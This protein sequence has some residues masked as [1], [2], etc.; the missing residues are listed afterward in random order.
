M[1]GILRNRLERLFHLGHKTLAKAGFFSFIPGRCFEQ[2][3]LSH[4]PKF[5]RLSPN[6]QM[7]FVSILPR[8]RALASSQRVNR[9][10]WAS[11]SAI[12]RS[13]ISSCQPGT[14]IAA[15]SRL[16]QICS[17]RSSR[18]AVDNWRALC[19]ISALFIRCLGLCKNDDPNDLTELP[20]IL[21]GNLDQS[22]LNLA[23]ELNSWHF[24]PSNLSALL[25]THSS[26]I[27]AASS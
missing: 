3:G 16:S 22:I 1:L 14:G 26:T 5:N 17:T 8:I 13:R 27:L 15:E 24:S 18:S 6:H 2:F 10:G 11:A 9:S 21:F 25:L 12:R 7:F 23:F 4:V 20:A 19:A